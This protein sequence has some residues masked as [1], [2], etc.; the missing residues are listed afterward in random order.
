MPTLVEL[1]RAF[2]NTMAPVAAGV[3]VTLRRET[4]SGAR[5]TVLEDVVVGFTDFRQEV[6]GQVKVH[7]HQ[8]D[9][10]IPAA[11]YAFDGLGA[12]KPRQGDRI[13][14]VIGGVT[15]YFE[16]NTPTGET[17]WKFHDSGET[18]YRVHTQPITKDFGS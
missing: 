11:S 6:Q 7:F 15:K 8:R 5:A 1:G 12:V 13:T 9:Y 10:F 4:G 16:V 14:E 17:P 2:R 18:T 3:T